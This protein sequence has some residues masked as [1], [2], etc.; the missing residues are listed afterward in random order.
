MCI[1]A[2]AQ[3][4]RVAY[5]G[6]C[7]GGGVEW[8]GLGVCAGGESVVGGGGA[9]VGWGGGAHVCVDLSMRLFYFIFCKYT[10]VGSTLHFTEQRRSHW[11]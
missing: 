4:V 6:M 9:E 5:V 11:G 7:V 8:L 2:R 3:R 10:L 1:R